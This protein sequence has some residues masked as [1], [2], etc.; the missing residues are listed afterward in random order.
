MTWKKLII[1]LQYILDSDS[2]RPCVHVNN[3]KITVKNF[4]GRK[5]RTN[6]LSDILVSKTGPGP[7]FWYYP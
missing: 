1:L 3:K 6:Y 2:F 7:V 4:E 5:N